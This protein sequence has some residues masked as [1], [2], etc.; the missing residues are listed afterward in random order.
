VEQVL[1]FTA[2][3]WPPDD[4]SSSRTVGTR[5][6]LTNLQS[7]FDALRFSHNYPPEIEN[8]FWS[9]ARND[10]V[11]RA[12]E[13]AAS[14]GYRSPYKRILEV[15]CGTGIV[16]SALRNA[17]L[18]IWG[19]DIGC[20]RVVDSARDR[21]TVA[22]EARDLEKQFRNTVE[23]L[24]F[25]DVVEHIE[26][27]VGFLRDTLRHFPN[28]SCVVITVPAGPKAWSRWDEYYGHFRRYTKAS[29]DEMVRKSGLSPERTR[30]FF[31]A[32]Y[33]AARVI[34][35]LGLQ[36]S[37]VVPAPRRILV[38]RLAA[39]LMIMEDKFFRASSVPGL[40]LIC[41][42]STDKEDV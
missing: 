21:V 5:E 41:V 1:N 18:D 13:E 27:D 10:L 28:C 25:L 8:Y 32:L 3:H 24:M 36:R 23:T 39:S 19:V 14:A 12:L 22:T 40:S 38:H 35:W 37:T 20:P 33:L 6:D 11:R 2:S 29:L 17:G 9:L 42:A 7:A 4:R 16:V 15:G 34:N 31:R 26:N 30:Y